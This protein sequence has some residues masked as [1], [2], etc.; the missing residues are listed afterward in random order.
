[1]SD[2]ACIS[3]CGQALRGLAFSDAGDQ[4]GVAGWQ[5]APSVLQVSLNPTKIKLQNFLYRS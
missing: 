1:M 3:S 5:D 2:S 4:T